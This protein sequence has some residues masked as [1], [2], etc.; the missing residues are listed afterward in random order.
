LSV[1]YAGNREIPMKVGS[2][3]ENKVA[4]IGSAM[5]IYDITINKSTIHRHC[6]V[7][8]TTIAYCNPIVS[9]PVLVVDTIFH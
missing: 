2:R 3:I 8:R 1:L 9:D 4:C 7:L 5:G 6:K